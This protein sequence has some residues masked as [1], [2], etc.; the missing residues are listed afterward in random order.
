M[1]TSRIGASGAD[2]ILVGVKRLHPYFIDARMIDEILEWI[3]HEQ[4]L[5]R[6]PIGDTCEAVGQDAEQDEA[7]RVATA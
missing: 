4:V 2:G 1:H 6:R 5:N 3:P 7:V